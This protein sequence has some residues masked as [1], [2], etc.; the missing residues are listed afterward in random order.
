MSRM[1][2]HS[3]Q[4]APSEIRP[5]IER[6]V[7]NNGFLPNLVATLANSPSAISAYFTLGDI[8]ASG[9]LS[10]AEREV[11]QIVAA[12]VH[13]CGFCVAGHTAVALKKAQLSDDIVQAARD[14]QTI[15]DQRLN[16]VAKLTQEVIASRGAVSDS[17]LAAF[18]QAGFND[19]NALDVVLGVS[20]A[21][22]CNFA[23]NLAGND[24]NP[25][26]H[27]YRWEPRKL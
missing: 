3:V 11:V 25:Q 2:L 26:M 16:A 14:G 24:L 1:H 6:S 20:L 15:Q 8:N 21:T 4:T 17:A 5:F 23:N 9:S 12:T 7:A 27:A 18:K 10:L 13:G 19:Q 22:L